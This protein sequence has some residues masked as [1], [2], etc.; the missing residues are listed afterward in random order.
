[1]N[2]RKR[3]KKALSLLLSALLV[4][5]LLPIGLLAEEETEETVAGTAE[6]STIIETAES[7][8]EDL[9]SEKPEEPETGEPDSESSE[10]DYEEMGEPL[11]EPSSSEEPEKE[12]LF[13][14]G[15]DV[16]PEEASP[17][18]SGPEESPEM[19]PAFVSDDPQDK[20]ADSEEAEFSVEPDTEMPDENPAEFAEG[21]DQVP[22]SSQSEETQDSKEELLEAEDTLLPS[23]SE[24][25]PISDELLEIDAEP[26]SGL[27]SVL[28]EYGYAYIR[29]KGE[30]PVFSLSS[31]NEADHFF[32]ITD[33]I[34]LVTS[35]LE[36]E[37]GNVLRVWY[38]SEDRFI[39]AWRHS[40]ASLLL[41]NRVPMKQIQEWLG[42]SDFSTTANIYAHLDYHS[43][44]DSAEAILSGLSM[45]PT[46]SEEK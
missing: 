38:V 29:V 5:S 31:C 44:I 46:I 42:H 20:I 15:T 19:E 25:S 9:I 41:A 43:K 14:D 27:D 21:E 4:F 12:E 40:C 36:R 23:E 7:P 34:L 33:G 6:E 39:C 32:T 1:M 30:T 13:E 26:A 16:N 18:D 3:M 24:D 35:L 45:M 37:N 17:E 28:A 11:E 10:E 8:A 2:K 22:D